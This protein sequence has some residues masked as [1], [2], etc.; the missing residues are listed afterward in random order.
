MIVRIVGFY[1]VVYFWITDGKNDRFDLISSFS[2]KPCEI[3]F[4]LFNPQTRAS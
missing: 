1:L 2:K 3:S 4:K